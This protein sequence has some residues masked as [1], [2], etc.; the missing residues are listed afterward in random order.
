MELACRDLVFHF[1]KKHLEN[2]TVPMWVIKTQGRTYYVDHVS[3]NIPWT[4]K[5]TPNNNH[6]KGSIKFKKALLTIEDNCA[7]IK[8]LSFE[9]AARLTKAK[10]VKIIFQ[11]KNQILSF[12][13][14]QEIE[15]SE[16]RY[17]EGACGTSWYVIE[18]AESDLTL[19]TI[20]Y[21]KSFRVLSENEYHY[22][23]FKKGKIVDVDPDYTYNLDN[24]EPI[25]IDEEY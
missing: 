16:C 18:L 3:A 4:T 5:E 23:Q 17:F 19:L 20:A 22:E 7:D 1:N 15:H 9:D 10:L 6:T 21:A 8:P 14:N 24:A 25:E 12:L 13:N 11:I 2:S